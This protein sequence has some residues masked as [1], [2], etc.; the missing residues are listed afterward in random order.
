MKQRP[1]RFCAFFLMA[2]ATVVALGGLTI[3]MIVGFS[4]TSVAAGAAVTLAGFILT[5]ISA[6]ILVAVAQ[7]WLLFVR[8]EERV[9]DIAARWKHKT[10]D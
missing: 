4:M 1:L 5:A 9:N 6:T 8:L 7:L 3:T 2:L 10:G